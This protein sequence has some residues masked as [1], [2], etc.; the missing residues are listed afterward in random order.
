MGF[1]KKCDS[2]RR[3]TL[4]ALNDKWSQLKDELFLTDLSLRNSITALKRLRKPLSWDPLWEKSASISL[5][6]RQL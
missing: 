3:G 1:S 6:K 4:S 2:L 5:A